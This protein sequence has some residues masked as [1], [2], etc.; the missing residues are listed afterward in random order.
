M[1][2]LSL[3]VALPSPVTVQSLADERFRLT[4][5]VRGSDPSSSTNALLALLAAAEHE[6]RGRGRA[7]GGDP[8]ELNEIPKTDAAARKR[9]RLSLS[10]EWRCD[11][12]R[13]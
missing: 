11:P 12:A 3:L 6:C 5:I 13:P 7:V 10:G 1:L 8:L 2:P 4:V 9:G